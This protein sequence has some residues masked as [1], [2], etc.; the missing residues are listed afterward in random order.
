MTVMVNVP[1]FS[2]LAD[3]ATERSMDIALARVQEYAVLTAPVD[4]GTYRRNIVVDFNADTVTAEIEYSRVVEYGFKGRK[5]TANMRNAARKV[6]R[7]IPQIFNNEF[8]KIK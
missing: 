4:S 8:R 7:E 3:L 5:P 2:K 6:Q 1:D